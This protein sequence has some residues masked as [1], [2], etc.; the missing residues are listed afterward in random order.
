MRASSSHNPQEKQKIK[1]LFKRLSSGNR[2][3]SVTPE[4]DFTAENPTD[5]EAQIDSWRAGLSAGLEPEF[6]AEHSTY[7]SKAALSEA[8]KARLE[9]NRAKREAKLKTA[10]PRSKGSK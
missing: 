2:T 10:K 1:V 8:R 6:S 9:R 3:D 5:F 4:I 7:F